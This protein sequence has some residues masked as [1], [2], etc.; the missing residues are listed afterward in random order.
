MRIA[1]TVDTT[2]GTVVPLT[3]GDQV[4]IYDT[5]TNGLERLPNPAIHAE[6]H[7][8]AVAVKFLADRQVY[9]VCSVPGSFCAHSYT[10][11]TRSGLEFV[12]LDAGTSTGALSAPDLAGQ[13][14]SV[15]PP[16]DLHQHGG[17]GHHH[18]H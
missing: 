12:R 14:V 17:G 15:L 11:A 4:W 18:L 9:A 8:R 5:E 13:V 10:L 7:R 2:S 3:Q 1:A 16:T 6:A